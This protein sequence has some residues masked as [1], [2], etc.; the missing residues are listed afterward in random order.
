MDTDS[1]AGRR[2]HR[3]LAA[4][5]LVTIAGCGRHQVIDPGTGPITQ[6]TPVRV[7]SQQSGDFSANPVPIKYVA[8]SQ[9]VDL[10]DR[11]ETQQYYKVRQGETLSGIARAHHIPLARLLDSNGLDASSAL[12]PGQLIF[13]PPAR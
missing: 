12:Q 2:R 1:D 9:V 4:L 7:V 3:S 10:P 5:C 8:A 6:Q 11:S 13:L